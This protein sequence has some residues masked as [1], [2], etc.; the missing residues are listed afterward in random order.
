[1]NTITITESQIKEFCQRSI[2]ELVGLLSKPTLIKAVKDDVESALFNK[3][4]KNYELDFDLEN[5]IRGLVKN[6]S[7]IGAKRK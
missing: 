4:G 7:P 2:K 6:A 5:Y 3:F 1:M